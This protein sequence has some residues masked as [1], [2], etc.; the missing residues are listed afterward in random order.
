MSQITE[1]KPGPH[2]R[3]VNDVPAKETSPTFTMRYEQAVESFDLSH[4]PRRPNRCKPIEEL[5]LE[6]EISLWDDL[7]DECFESFENGLEDSGN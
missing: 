7:S 4:A 6:Q 5:T 2:V 3:L 1:K